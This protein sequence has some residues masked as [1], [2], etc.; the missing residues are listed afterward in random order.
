MLAPKKRKRTRFI[1]EGRFEHLRD[2]ISGTPVAR[3][4]DLDVEYVLQEVA[5]ALEEWVRE[6]R[7][8]A[9]R[10]VTESSVQLSVGECVCCMERRADMVFVPCGHMS[11]CER[12][13][14]RM[15]VGKNTKCPICRRVG[16]GIKVYGNV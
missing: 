1:N 7:H 8:T 13:V 10:V 5:T 14:S 12:C 6:V 2:S 11:C 4:L 15:K 16:K 3:Q 9:T